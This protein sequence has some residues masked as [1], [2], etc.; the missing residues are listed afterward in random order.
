MWTRD[1][2]PHAASEGEVTV[3]SGRAAGLDRIAY[4]AKGKKV[5]LEGKSDA[6]GRWYAGTVD[7]DPRRPRGG[8]RRATTPASTA[9]P[10]PRDA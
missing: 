6:N 9:P 1:K 10:V 4:E 7:R 2:A 5:V 8:G 3:W